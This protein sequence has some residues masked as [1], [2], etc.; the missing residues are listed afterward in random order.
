MYVIA[1][2]WRSIA[3]SIAGSSSS[4]SAVSGT[5]TKPRPCRRADISYITNPGNGAR[6]VAPGTSLARA[7]SEINSSEPLPSISRQPAGNSTWLDSAATTS[8]TQPVG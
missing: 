4:K 1:G 3:S 6:I 5:P 7:S 8:P 2:R